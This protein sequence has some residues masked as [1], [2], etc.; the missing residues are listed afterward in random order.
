MAGTTKKRFCDCMRK[1]SGEEGLLV[2]ENV[3]GQ[4]A[5]AHLGLVIGVRYG[6]GRLTCGRRGRH[7]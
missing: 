3:L 2:L 5:K 6:L 1:R 7:G 4:R